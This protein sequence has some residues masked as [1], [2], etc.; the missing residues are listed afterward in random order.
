LFKDYDIYKVQALHVSLVEMDALSL[1]Y[2]M[3]KFIQKVVKPSTLTEW[4]PILRPKCAATT[5]NLKKGKLLRKFLSV[6][7]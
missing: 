3:T 5:T 6:L 1:N 4:Y 2:W 7:F